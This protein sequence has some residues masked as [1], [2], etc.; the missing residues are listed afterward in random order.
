M[1]PPNIGGV[2]DSTLR[3]AVHI[4]VV[5][6]TAAADLLPGQDVAVRGGVYAY[7]A[8][9]TEGIGI[10]DPYRK[11][12]VKAGGRF[13]L[14]MRKIDGAPRHSW[15]SPDFPDEVETAREEGRSEGECCYGG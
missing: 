4:P 2:P 9:E 14:F 7:A 6:V 3:D 1:T 11:G 10:V 13:W 5:A 8:P 12:P 15:T